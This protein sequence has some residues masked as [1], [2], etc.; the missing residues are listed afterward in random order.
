MRKWLTG[1]IF[2]YF[3]YGLLVYW[4]LFIFSGTGVPAP[5]EGSSADPSTFMSGRELLLSQEY[6]TIKNF[7]FFVTVPFEWFLLFVIL[8]TGISRKMQEWSNVT[9]RFFSLQSAVYF[10]WLSLLISVISFPVELLG[11]RISKSYNITTQTFSAWMKDQLIDFWVN[12]ALMTVIVIVLYWL[13]K[14]F[15]KRWWLYAW[16]LS[17]PF[18]MFLMFV[19]PV[20]IDPLYNDF[21]PLQNKELE[22]KILAIANEADIPAEHVY[23]VNMSEKTNALNAYVTGIGS[24]SRIVLW[25]TTLNRLSEEEILFIMAHE[26][27][28]YVMNHIYVGIAGYLFLSLFGLFIIHLL[29][30]LMIKQF[31]SLLKINSIRELTAFPLFLILL[32]VL[33]FASSPLANTVARY[34][35]KSADMYAIEMTNNNEAA[36]SSFQELSRAGLS[37]VNPPALVK[38]FRYT[39][40]TMFE[41]I[42]YLEEH[43]EK[44]SGSE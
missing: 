39:H 42:L 34:Q 32:G 37:E 17:I 11:F 23:E 9:S 12:Y 18:S 1:S 36:I 43:G 20:L 35:E 40:P 10:F 22:E 14:R 13:I 41:R 5:Y 38:I 33:T 44:E 19:Q 21:Y 28:H 4:Y 16:L 31:G 3:L 25:D 24:N 29:M 6:S 8:I 26:M 2:L 30:K 7:L 15:E 27:G